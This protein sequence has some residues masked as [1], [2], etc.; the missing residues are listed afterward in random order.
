MLIIAKSKIKSYESLIQ[1][2][3]IFDLNPI[4]VPEVTF[5]VA[6]EKKQVGSYHI[7]AGAF[8]FEENADKKIAQLKEARFFC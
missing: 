8:R 2:A 4:E 6:V 3:S 7:I 5:N 1:R